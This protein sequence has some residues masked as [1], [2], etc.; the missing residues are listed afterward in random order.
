MKMKPRPINPPKKKSSS[1]FLF[2][3]L[4][5]IVILTVVFLYTRFLGS[6]SNS[7]RWNKYWLWLREGTKLEEATLSAKSTCNDAPFLF[8]L[9]GVVFGLW[10]ESYR[11]GHRHTGIDIFPGTEVGVAPIY[12]VYDGYLSR[13]IGW[14][15]TVI[16]R[17]PSDPLNPSRQIWTYYTHMAD[18][19]GN[20]FI[21]NQFPEG[22][23]EVLI[24]AGTFLGY[25]GNYSGN[26]TNPTGT[27]LH[28]SIV[29]D[30]NGDYL[31]ELDINNTYDPSP[32]FG[33]PLNQNENP[34]NFPTCQSAP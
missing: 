8:P 5:L 24:P 22:T 28:I 12:A 4:I 6:T 21:S 33:L 17:I 25:V 31:N 9:D 10:D 29:K 16:I 23:S 32:Y 1:L 30:H 3:G 11:Q 7:A 27:H 34:D 19:Q 15:S 14:K 18:K 2:F 13:E 20:S 26:P